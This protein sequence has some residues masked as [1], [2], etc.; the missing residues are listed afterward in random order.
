MKKTVFGTNIFEYRMKEYFRKRASIIDAVNKLYNEQ[1]ERILDDLFRENQE[2]AFHERK[3]AEREDAIE[4]RR[5]EKREQREKK[6]VCKEEKKVVCKEENKC[7]LTTQYLNVNERLRMYA[8]NEYFSNNVRNFFERY[9]AEQERKLYAH[10]KE[11]A[12][13]MCK[14]RCAKNRKAQEKREQ[15][16]QAIKTHNKYVREKLTLEQKKHLPFIPFSGLSIESG[17]YVNHITKETVGK[18][19]Q[20]IVFPDY[21][22]SDTYMFDVYNAYL[23]SSYFDY[24]QVISVLKKTYAKSGSPFIYVLMRQAQIQFRN[25]NRLNAKQEISVQ[26][27]EEDKIYNRTFRKYFKRNTKKVVFKVVRDTAKDMDICSNDERKKDVSVYEY[28]NVNDLLGVARE[29]MHKLYMSGIVCVPS[30]FG[31]YRYSVQKEVQTFIDAQRAKKADFMSINDDDTVSIIDAEIAVNDS[32]PLNYTV[33]NTLIQRELSRTHK[34]KDYNVKL[35][36]KCFEMYDKYGM[37]Q[38]EIAQDLNV[39]IMKVSRSIRDCK[40]AMVNLK[41]LL[42]A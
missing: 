11:I 18:K 10:R 30:D 23:E 35:V 9:N 39:S 33:N 24:I 20:Y 38:E 12:E 19:P 2:I 40:E 6:A 28:F 22:R 29:A 36:M 27:K 21:E 34:R 14:E 3:R 8:S 37:K 1:I 16:K 26:A 5:Q 13:Q 7:V 17:T 15:R 41:E 4:K 32:Y 42:I 31:K 25:K